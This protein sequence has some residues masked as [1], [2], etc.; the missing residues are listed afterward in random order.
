MVGAQDEQTR[1]AIKLD[2]YTFLVAVLVY[3]GEEESMSPPPQ[4]KHARCTSLV[5]GVCVW[6][7][8]SL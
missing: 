4:A 8:A 6:E 7:S 5:F 1:P 2:K 3:V